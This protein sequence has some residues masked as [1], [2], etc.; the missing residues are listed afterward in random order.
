MGEADVSVSLI[1]AHSLRRVA[2]SSSNT[3]V[4]EASFVG[5]SIPV[6]S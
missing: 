4:E 2:S 5:V 6:V 3:V 1:E